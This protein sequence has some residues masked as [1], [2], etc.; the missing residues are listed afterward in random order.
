[1]PRGGTLTIETSQSESES[2]ARFVV[3]SVGDS[4]PEPDVES[5]REGQITGLA[6]ATAYGIVR[7]MGETISFEM[8]P[9]YGARIVIH[10]SLERMGAA[11]D[12]FCEMLAR[13]RGCTI[14]RRSW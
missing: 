8:E 2:G 5:L 12:S 10:V 9:G 11:P 7:Q 6:L 14:S 13:P 4:R 1:M 3:L